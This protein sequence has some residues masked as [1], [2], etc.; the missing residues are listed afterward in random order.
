[1][2]S[3]VIHRWLGR[4]LML[5]IAVV[6]G[7]GA[8]LVYGHEIEAWFQPEIRRPAGE[9]SAGFGALYDAVR[10]AA[11]EA[12]VQRLLDPGEGPLAASA[13]ILR[14]GGGRAALW[15]DPAT[16]ALQGE[17]SGVGP[18]AI[19][20]GLHSTVML[21]NRYAEI[22]A[23]LIIFPLALHLVVGFLAERRMLR[24]TFRAPW[25]RGEAPR[26]RW[27]RM[28]RVAGLWSLP[29]MTITLL[30]GGVFILG[31]LGMLP[32]PAPR[33]APAERAEPLPAGFDGAAVDRAV[34]AAQAA[35]PG[36]VPR[37]LRLP[38]RERDPIL[39]IGEDAGGGAAEVT[40]DPSDLSVLGTARLAEDGALRRAVALNGPLHE[41]TFA[42]A[43]SKLVWFVS[44]LL[45]TLVA[46]SGVLVAAWRLG[47]AG[48]ASLRAAIRAI[49]LPARIATGLAF[50]LMVALVL[51]AVA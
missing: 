7:S 16:A 5:Y 6:F 28:H 17:T 23:S 49:F 51:R 25:R 43:A 3:M 9:G 29:V 50:L 35:L 41:G 31:S 4:V 21:R 32:G 40:V 8:L 13:E 33:P 10:A 2:T 1:M 39:V 37:E 47:G 48:R 22:V 15:F 42:G 12:R 19:L 34:A 26:L 27:A 14:Q 20:I 24:W 11:P 44:G 36:L 46:V 45:A 30:T 38:G 18:R